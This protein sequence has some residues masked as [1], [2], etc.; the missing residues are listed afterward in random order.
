MGLTFKPETD[1]LRES[2][3]VEL[4]ERLIG[5][6]YT[7]RIYDREV[8]L[9]R[10][11]GSNKRYIE[12]VIPHISGLMSDSLED[13]VRE[14]EVIVMAKGSKEYEGLGKEICNGKTFV[15]LARI[16]WLQTRNIRHEG[17]CW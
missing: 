14:S 12:K 4:A 5:K 6:G 2:P 10:L 3:M 17:I 7:L 11:Y 15:D 1:D 16:D 8:S 9:A 13:V